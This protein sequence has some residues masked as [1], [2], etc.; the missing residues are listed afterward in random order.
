[1]RKRPTTSKNRNRDHNCYCKFAQPKE[2]SNDTQSPEELEFYSD[3]EG[4]SKSIKPLGE[5]AT[6]ELARAIVRFERNSIDRARFV[7]VHGGLIVFPT[8]T[9]YGLGCDPDNEYAVRRLSEAKKRDHRPI[10][11]LC[12]SKGAAMELV[13]MNQKAL[14]LAG[15]FWPGALT[16]VAPLKRSLPY[17]LHQG[18]GTLGVRVPA[19][20]LCVA[21][22]ETCGGWLTGTSANLSGLPSARTAAEAASQLGDRVDLIL[23]GG[24]LEGLESTV[25]RVVDDGI[26]V[27][28]MGQVRVT[29][30]RRE[31]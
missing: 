1:M 10:P 15:R 23:D 14:E 29:D 28:R 22:I 11:V 7:V 17:L 9:V 2:V 6:R 13:E 26:Q 20:P 4:E 18:T 8:D 24:K 31:R 30:E 21:L 3:S 25:V 12:S 16:I 27:L 5:S 19:L